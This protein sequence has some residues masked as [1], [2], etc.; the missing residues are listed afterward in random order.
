MGRLYSRKGFGVTR[1]NRKRSE[2][3]GP[4]ELRGI[5]FTH[6]QAK[7]HSWKHPLLVQ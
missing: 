4:W 6:L 7:V 3:T 2:Q 5:T 1:K